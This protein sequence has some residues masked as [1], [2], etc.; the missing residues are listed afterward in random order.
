MTIEISAGALV[1]FPVAELPFVT[2]TNPAAPTARTGTTSS[3]S[4]DDYRASGLRVN[5]DGQNLGQPAVEPK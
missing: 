5:R 4:D 3:V 2:A 1:Q